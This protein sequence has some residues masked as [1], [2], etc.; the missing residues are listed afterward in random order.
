[1]NCINQNMSYFKHGFVKDEVMIPL[2]PFLDPPLIYEL[3]EIKD[4]CNQCLVTPYVSD[5]FVIMQR[6][7][8]LARSREC[9]SLSYDLDVRFRGSCAVYIFWTTTKC[10]FIKYKQY[11]WIHFRYG[12]CHIRALQ[13]LSLSTHKGIQTWTLALRA[14]QRWN[15]LVLILETKGLFQFEI[16][17]N[18]LVSS[19]R[20]IWIPML[21]VYGH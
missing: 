2:T 4:L 21:W 11:R 18:V 1:M 8:S 16:I 6:A 19:I 3:L 20:F 10:I 17:S 13:V 15:I 7:L 5:P 9:A 14:L 12:L